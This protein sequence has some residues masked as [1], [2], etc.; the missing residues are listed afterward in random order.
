MNAVTPDITQKRIEVTRAD[1]HADLRLS[2]PMPATTLWNM[3]PRV[4]LPIAVEKEVQCPYC[5]TIYVL[6]D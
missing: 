4:Y 2:C 3:H 6:K 5:S 1:L